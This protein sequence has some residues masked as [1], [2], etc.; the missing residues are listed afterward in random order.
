MQTGRLNWKLRIDKATEMGNKTILYGD[1]GGIAQLVEHCA[2]S[3]VVSGSTPL[4]STT[5]LRIRT[6]FSTY[7]SLASI[8][9][10]VQ[11]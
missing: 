3:A 4:T 5:T 10:R 11:C 8:K 2:G 1:I 6:I 7:E 9:F